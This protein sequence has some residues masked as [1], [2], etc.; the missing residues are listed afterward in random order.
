MYRIKLTDM[1]SEFFYHLASV[2]TPEICQNG[3]SKAVARRPEQPCGLLWPLK[4]MMVQGTAVSF[5][6]FLANR[7]VLLLSMFHVNRHH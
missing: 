3:L 1:I 6:H 5:Q 7:M 4:N 2:D